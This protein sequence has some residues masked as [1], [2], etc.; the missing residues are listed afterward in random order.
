M[1]SLGKRLKEARK[2]KKLTQVDVALKIGSDDTTISKYENDRSE[3]DKDTL[4]L[5]ADIYGVSVDYL[6]GRTNKKEADEPAPK[7]KLDLAVERIEYDLNI[8]IKDDPMIMEA[9][10]NYIQTLGN[11]KKDN[12]GK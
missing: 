2:L 8:S 11:I 9:L 3:P 10:V 6:Y 7:S 5:L 12:Q 4:N 1:I